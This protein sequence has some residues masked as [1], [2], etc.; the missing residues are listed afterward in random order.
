V[1]ACTNELIPVK[2]L[3]NIAGERYEFVSCLGDDLMGKII[4]L[5]EKGFDNRELS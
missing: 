5:K 4:W 2:M 1:G 3:S